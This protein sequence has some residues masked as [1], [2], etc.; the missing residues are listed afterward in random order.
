MQRSRRPDASSL[1]HTC[2]L[3]LV[4]L[5]AVG[6]WA[7]A[8]P[9]ISAISPNSGSTAGGT[10]ITI[11]GSGFAAGATVSI[12]GASATNVV[13]S[14]SGVITASTPAHAAGTV[15]V[16]VA[17]ADGQ[18]ATLSSS[19]F[20]LLGNPGFE[21]G[22]TRWLFNG[23]GTFSTQTIPTSA[24][25]GS[26]YAELTS[27][28]GKQPVLFGT[29]SVGGV[30]FPVTPGDVITFGGWAYRVSGDGYARWVLAAVD[31]NQLNSTYVGSNPANVTTASWI[32]QVSSYT[33][34]SGKAYIRFY[35]EIYANTVT[36]DARFDDAILQR[37]TVGGFNYISSSPTLTSISVS[38]QNAALVIG[39]NQ[40][41]SATG[42]YS[43]GTTKDLTTTAAWSSSSTAV[44]TV[45]SGG[46]AKAV[47]AGSTTIKAV[48]NSVSGS[49]SLNVTSSG[50][51]VTI[52]PRATT[53]TFKT[54]QQFT[55]STA[56]NWYV[57]GLLGGNATVGMIS[58]TGL[59][60]PPSTVGSHQIRAISQADASQSGTATVIVTNFAGMF[61]YHYDNTRRGANT[62]EIAL[63]PSNVNS[64]QFGKL[65]SIKVDGWLHAQPLYVQNV[66]IGGVFHNV[67][68][69]A[70]EHDSVYAFDADHKQTTPYWK[71]SFINATAGITPV[72]TLDT[73][74][75][76]VAQP[77]FGIMS[78][79]AIDPG[80]G[81]IYVVARTK[82]NGS[83]FVRLHA[84][85][86]TTGKE[87]F[88]GPVA[89]VVSVPGNGSGNDGAGH[90]PF[91]A[92]HQNIRPAVLLSNG[93]VYIASASVD[94][95]G[96]YHGWVF[97]YDASDLALRGVWNSSPNGADGGIWHSGGGP[98]ADS[99][100]AVYVLT[101]NGTF[102]PSTG[103][104]GHS[105]IKLSLGLDG[106]T[107]DD[108]FTPKNVSTL[109]VNDWDLTSGA[110]MLLPDQP[111][112]HPHVMLGG[113]KQGTLY[114]IDRDSLGKFNSTTDPAVQELVGV[115]SVSASCCDRGLWSTP[116]YWNNKI[117]V[118]GRIDVVKVF[119]LSGG[120]LSTSPIQTGTV[121]MRGPTLTI[122]SN[123]ANNGILWA[124][125]FDA[126]S[127]SGPTILHAF[128][129]NNITKELYNSTQ[130]GT[131][132]AAGT[133]IKFAVPTVA[134]G[135]VYIDA[136]TEVDVYGLLP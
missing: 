56:S 3:V 129:A 32:R 106:L 44:A 111:S 92:L 18:S 65:F 107:L 21:S 103:G 28:V 84:L 108:Y 104:Y 69:I 57:D 81:T 40:Q 127:S 82:E 67:V 110:V 7:A 124:V 88:G 24:H 89:L 34:P 27:P 46:L 66:N 1:R 125:Q 31:I 60:Q 47:A 73:G 70:T 64:S 79:P 55:A 86:I 45:T 122:S 5:F 17:N 101:G 95:I 116:T 112:S 62:Q 93:I 29:N 136:Q 41:Y 99:T 118:C 102:N 58:S 114:L 97:A 51:G 96:P 49:S 132:D 77:E 35:S 76:D 134:N 37:T 14:S 75:G 43:D 133:A 121:N 30:Y 115:I 130:A 15:P 59:Y 90:V 9:T 53:V 16:T 100:G 52:T 33:V 20:Q 25:S 4:L 36:A 8:A 87:K 72:P 39:A 26:N 83:Y 22:S 6:A 71:T 120:L 126:Q 68:Y 78:T 128:D 50:A 42:H 109:N 119:S 19:T 85:D 23:S 113:G 105:F 123:G 135:R 98:A 117:Y 61:T 54:K 74:A 63:T 13:V 131:R 94:D 80:T 12:G 2:L 48:S 38:P 10:A 91:D 11:T